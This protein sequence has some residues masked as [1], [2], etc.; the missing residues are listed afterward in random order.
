MDAIT[1]DM[2]DLSIT[3]FWKTIERPDRALSMA[4]E[5]L[6]MISEDVVELHFAANNTYRPVKGAEEEH[7]RKGFRVIPYREHYSE[8]YEKFKGGGEQTAGGTNLVVLEAYGINIDLR[9]FCKSLKIYSVEALASLQSQ[10]AKSLGMHQNKL[11]EAARKF[12]ADRQ[13][14]QGQLDEIAELRA[15]LEELKK[16]KPE[17]LQSFNDLPDLADIANDPLAALTDAEIKEQ[18]KDLT[19]HMPRGNPSRASLIEQ[20]KEAQG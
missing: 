20:L 5:E 7:S 19:G 8:S 6:V 3:P 12:L 13:S 11:Q 1:L 9:N 15:Q 16:A 2:N 18:I 14:G 4:K 10:N 17:P